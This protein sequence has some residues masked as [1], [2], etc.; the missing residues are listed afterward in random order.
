MTFIPKSLRCLLLPLL[1][2]LLSGCAAV[3]TKFDQMPQHRQMAP[4]P[5]GSVCRVAIL[6]LQNGSDFP[7]A[8]A[9]FSK[10]LTA[11]F[12]AASNALVVPE[13]DILKV[14]QQLRILPGAAPT[15][16]Q[17][18]LVASRLEAQL[19]VTGTIIE[20]R[21]NPGLNR[22]INPVLAVDLLLRDGQSTEPL[23]GVYHR[24]QGSDYRTAMHF[25]TI[26]TVTGLS[27]QVAVEIINHWFK[28]GFPRCD[29]SPRS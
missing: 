2:L 24:R 29:V 26:H 28:K 19:L 20:M 8:D 12:T 15:P 6:P 3:V 16:E 4:L 13:G 7:L 23:W 9:I 21:E 18:L 1:L 27:H 22:S 10:V 14:Y 17:L 11:Q 5:S 25:G